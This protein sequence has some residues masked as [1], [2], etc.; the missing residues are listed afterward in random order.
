[1]G[2]FFDKENDID[3]KFYELNNEYEKCIIKINVEKLD[4][5]ELKYIEDE[6]I[7]INHNT[8]NLK[9]N[10]IIDILKFVINKKVDTIIKYADYYHFNLYNECLLEI[11]NKNAKIN[12]IN[13]NVDE[14]KDYVCECNLTEPNEGKKTYLQYIE[15]TL[16]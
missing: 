7:L 4:Y 13:D 2:N 16:F 9:I 12:R 5:E 14:G 1:M 8:L 11:Y 6:M 10:D 3:L 15:E